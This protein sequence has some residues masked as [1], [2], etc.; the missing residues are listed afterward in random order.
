M[1]SV[2]I[3]NYNSGAYLKSCVESL[4]ANSDY[5]VEILV[6]DNHSTDNSLDQLAFLKS[7][8]FRVIKNQSNLGFAAACNQGLAE[9]RGEFLVTMN[10][11]VLVPP[12]WLGRLIWH[13]RNNPR[14]LAV[15]P[16]GIGI[17]GRQS[18]GPLCFSSRL[19]P[20]DRKFAR[21]N[22]RQSERT[23]FLIGC[24]LLFDRRLLDR[25]GYFDEKLTLGADDFDLSLRIRQAGFDLR[26]ARDL[27][28]RHFVH[29]SFQ[30]SEPKQCNQMELESYRHFHQKWAKELSDFGW[31]RLFYGPEPVFPGEKK[32]EIDKPALF[33]F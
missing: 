1:V 26:V 7:P 9:A 12:A 23:K 15:G 6:I 28:I 5:P 19:I 30:R 11:D 31:E 25:I 24:L 8:K 18:P 14:T 13:L 33:A 10:P 27:L 16:K 20:A 3:V 32:Y 22:F 4:L 17:G 29:V 2:I 21:L